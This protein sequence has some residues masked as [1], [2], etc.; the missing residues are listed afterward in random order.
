MRKVCAWCGDKLANLSGESGKTSHGICDACSLDV[1]R[2]MSQPLEDFLNDLD[3]PI[4]LIDERGKFITGNNALK[5][6]LGLPISTGGPSYIGNVMECIYAD[7]QGSCGRDIH[8]NG[9]VMRRSIELTYQTGESCEGIP[10][11]LEHDIN[12]RVEVSWYEISTFKLKDKV[13][14]KVVTTK[15]PDSP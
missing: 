4:M 3:K 12:G 11:F 13:L 10:A 14:L 1:F 8:C 7:D 9:C 6:K 2:E 15:E 5:T